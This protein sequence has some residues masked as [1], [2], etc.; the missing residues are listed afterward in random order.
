MGG[1]GPYIDFNLEEYEERPKH[2]G[3]SPL[4][5]NVLGAIW[6]R[7]HRWLMTSVRMSC[8][9]TDGLWNKEISMGR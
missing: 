8:R 7:A 4:P 6:G 3:L 2:T 1:A 5:E 9:A